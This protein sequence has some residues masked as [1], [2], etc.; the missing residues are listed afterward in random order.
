MLIH[1]YFFFPD[2]YPRRPGLR[3]V[4][5]LPLRLLQDQHRHGG[6]PG[7]GDAVI[8]VDATDDTL[9]DYDDDEI[10]GRPPP[11]AIVHADLVIFIVCRRRRR[12]ARH[13]CI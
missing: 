3:P 13:R 7:R 10:L 6:E 5:V 8:V 12:Q 1:R 4:R 9:E 11:Q 2:G